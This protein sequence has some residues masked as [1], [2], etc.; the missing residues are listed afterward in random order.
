MV[1][2]KNLASEARHFSWRPA[3][4]PSPMTPAVNLEEVPAD[5]N[6]SQSGVEHSPA[7]GEKMARL[8]ELLFFPKWVK[9]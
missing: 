9:L 3:D 2:S 6:G 7:E 5:P 1:E 4:M 8:G